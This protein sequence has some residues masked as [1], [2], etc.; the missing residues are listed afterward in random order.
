[1]SATADD[2]VIAG[3]GNRGAGSPSKGHATASSDDHAVV[4]R[5]RA[6][7]ADAFGILVERHGDRLYQTLL[8]LVRGDHEMAGELVQEAFV[9]AF[10]RLDRFHGDSSFGTWLYR[11]ARNRAID[12]LARKR[13]TA[14]AGETLEAAAD[15][16]GGTGPSDPTA[17]MVSDETSA[18]VRKALA[19]IPDA[20]REL[21][22]MRD[23]QDLDYAEI[24]ERLEVPVGTIKSRLSRAR[25]ALR[26]AVTA[27]LPGG[28]P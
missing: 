17:N 11:L 16:R 28:W 18:A 2:S 7:D 15:H 22:L 1:M 10:E 27:H 9:R 19:E 20:S 23:F 4:A 24:A 25:A 5:V 12:V 21:I 8:H 14:L 3:P 6:G 26:E 13:P